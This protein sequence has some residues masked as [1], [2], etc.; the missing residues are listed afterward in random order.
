MRMSFGLCVFLLA[1]SGLCS[2][3]YAIEKLQDSDCMDGAQTTLE[4]D[5][6]GEFK[7]GKLNLQ[8]DAVFKKLTSTLAN[9]ECCFSED[10]LMARELAMKAQTH[11]LSFREAECDG[12]RETASA[13]SLRGSFFLSC[14]ISLTTDRIKQLSNWGVVD[15]KS[16]KSNSAKVTR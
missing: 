2:S 6:C 5:H 16:P 11:W 3:T 10:H 9:S 7:L 1:L 13:G 15:L 14:A 12:Q 4:M 8:M